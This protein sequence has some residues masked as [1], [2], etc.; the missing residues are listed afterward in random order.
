MHELILRRFFEG[1]ATAADLAADLDD[2]LVKG[3]NGVTLHPIV[4]MA[5]PFTVEASHLVSVCDA[6]LAEQIEPL[7]LRAIGF[8]LAASDAFDWNGESAEGESVATVALD[9]SCPE[10]NYPLSLENVVQ[11]RKRL[12]GGV[13]QFVPWPKGQRPKLPTIDH[14]KPAG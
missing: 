11:W 10:G 6:V 2:S 7:Y 13:P 12:L 5:E 4:D 8:C 9:W 3:Q 14:K 1:R